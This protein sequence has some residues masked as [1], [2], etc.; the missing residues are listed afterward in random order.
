M[1]KLYIIGNGFDLWHGLPTGYDHFYKFA[2]Q[3]L[4]EIENYYSFE[5]THAGPWS[6]FETSLGLFE[7]DYFYD[8]H[9]HIDVTSESFKPSE[10]YG[11][12]DDLTEQAFGHGDTMEESDEVHH[13]QKLVNC[14]V[15]Y[16]SIRT[17]AYEELQAEQYNDRT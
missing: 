9:N 3:L 1:K 8:A 12:E 10:V 6:D 2:K 4:D 7:W 13:A 16:E 5:M 14:G 11:L 15:Q 17:C